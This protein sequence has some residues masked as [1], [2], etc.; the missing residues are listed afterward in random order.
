MQQK[1]KLVKIDIFIRIKINMQQK[2]K[3]VKIDIFIRIKI[4]YWEIEGEWSTFKQV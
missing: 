3:L 4:I 2:A 1:A